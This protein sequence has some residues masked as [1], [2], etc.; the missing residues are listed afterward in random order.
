MDLGIELGWKVVV[1]TSDVAGQCSQVEVVGRIVPFI[2]RSR[3]HPN[4]KVR[5][6]LDVGVILETQ[7]ETAI[8]FINR[9]C[10]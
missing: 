2:F 1:L 3:Q 9:R 7:N 10:S 6:V 5:S 8:A 4:V